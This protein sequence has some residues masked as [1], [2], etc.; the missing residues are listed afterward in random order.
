MYTLIVS[1][2]VKPEH[3]QDF[4]KAALQ[5]GHDSLLN[6]PGTQRFEVIEDERNPNRFIL[7]E[8]YADKAAFDAHATGPYFQAFAATVTDYYAQKP[9]WLVR[10]PV[11]PASTDA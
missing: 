1:I 2:E 8:V 5:D 4:V 11:T 7:S 6:E 9:V 10:G 3:R